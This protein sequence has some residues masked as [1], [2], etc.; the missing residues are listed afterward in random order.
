MSHS[1]PHN[2]THTHNH[3]ISQHNERKMLF[4]LI[5][6]ASFMFVEITGGI[7]SSSLALIADAGHML[8]DAAALALSYTAFRLSRRQPNSQH[9]FGYTRFEV[10]AGFINALA[11]FAIVAWILFEAIERFFS[12]QQVLATPMMIVAI[13]GLIVNIVVFWILSQGDKD[14]VNIKGAAIHV[15]GDLLGSVGAI[16]AG[17]IIYF[18]GWMPIDPILS[19]LVSLLILRSAWNL[20]KETTYIL[21]EASPKYAQPEQVKEHLMQTI[22][23]LANVHHIHIW[24]LTSGRILATLHI[25]L[26][27]NTKAKSVVKKVEEELHHIFNI[28]HCTIAIDWDNHP[29]LCSMHQAKKP[30]IH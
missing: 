28:E 19:V 4:S 12:P 22:T 1:H 17:I 9:T 13:F 3:D 11:M 16:L 5:L 25:Q 10:V 27:D 18:T 23:E 8:T 30:H 7:L 26:N 20:L 2:H 15:M 24:T 21:L 14:H 6:I 29:H